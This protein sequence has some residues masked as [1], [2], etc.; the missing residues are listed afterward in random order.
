[1]DYSLE[2]LLEEERSLLLATFSNDDAW[3]LGVGLASLARE[4]KL[5]IAVSIIRGNQRLFH[6]A[7]PGMS[8]DNDLWLE[9][10]LATALH[11]GHSSLYMELKLQDL[12]MTMEE[13]Y[14]LDPASFA[15][16][17]GAIPIMLAGTGVVAGL[18]VSGLKGSEDHALAVEALRKFVRLS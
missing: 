11:F 13:K 17:G 12:G 14:A 16:S 5:A 6:Y 2:S 7:A 3:S 4:R 1:M 9:R 8:H 18:A 10:K 15:T